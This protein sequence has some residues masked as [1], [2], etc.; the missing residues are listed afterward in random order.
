MIQSL[1]ILLKSVMTLYRELKQLDIEN[2]VEWSTQIP[3]FVR[4]RQVFPVAW[5]DAK[6]DYGI[7]F[8]ANRSD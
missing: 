3:G 8:G 2:S 6:I 7:P 5:N 1:K 4:L